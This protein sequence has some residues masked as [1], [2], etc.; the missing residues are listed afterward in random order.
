MGAVEQRSAS[1]ASRRRRRAW[2]YAPALESR[3]IV[4]LRA[5]A[6]ASSSAG[7]Q[8][9]PRS[10]SLVHD[11]LAGDRGAARR[12]RAGRAEGRRPAPSA[13]R[14]SAFEDGGRPQARRAREVLFRI[15]RVLQE[16]AR[17]LAV[18]ESLDGG[19]P[20]KESRDVDL[21]LAA[22]HFFYYAGLGRQARVR[23]PGRQAAAARRRRRRSSR[24]T[25]RS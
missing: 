17:E 24:G 22:A 4:S 1:D 16:R 23:L 18:A 2:E 10:R 11:G 25:S 19:K 14:A 3:E 7:R 15:A 9:E 6:T 8:V 12:D 21:P 5:T 20:I 13:P